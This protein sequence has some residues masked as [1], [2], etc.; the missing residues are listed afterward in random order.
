M[1]TSLV[2]VHVVAAMIWFGGGVYGLLLTRQATVAG[3]DGAIQ[4]YLGAVERV[5]GPVFG[6]APPLTALA[7]IGLVIWSDQWE[8][9]QMWVYGALVLFAITAVSGGVL[10]TK[11]AKQ[12]TAALT[13]DG[14]SSPAFAR[15]MEKISLYG[16]I[17]VAIL[18]L[19][20]ALMVFKPGI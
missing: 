9:S 7:G 3:E 18:T 20:V 14:S 15:A 5:N 1:Y 4:R 19:I 13:E 10:E 16:W 8:F 12:A 11:A 2:L 6:I 17:D